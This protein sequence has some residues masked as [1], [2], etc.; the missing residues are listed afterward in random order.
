MTMKKTVILLLVSFLLLPATLLAKKKKAEIAVPKSVL[1]MDEQQY[2]D[3]LYF[4]AITQEQCHRLDSAINLMQT[5]VNFYDSALMS[6]GYEVGMSLDAPIDEEDD[7]PLGKPVTSIEAPGLAA[8]LFFLSN[9]YRQQNNAV[10]SIVNIA[11]ATAIDSVNYWYNDAHADLMMVLKRT[12]DAQVVYERLARNYPDKSQPLYALSDIYLRQDSTDKCLDVLNRLE[13]IEGGSPQLTEYKFFILQKAGRAEEGFEEYRKLIT[14]HPYN[15]QYRIKLGD[16]QMQNAQIQDAKKTYDEAA[17][18]E[19]DNAYVWIALSNYYS[20]TGN[21][22]EADS[23]VTE[24]LV[25]PNL[26]VETKNTVMTEYLKGTY[27]KFATYR[28]RLKAG[29]ADVEPLDT[30]ALLHK[31]DELFSTV[32]AQ[33]PS[34]PEFYE[35]QSEWFSTQ[36]KDSIAAECIRFAVDL[37]PTNP[38][39]WERYLY[40]STSWL[41]K[42]QMIARCDEALKQHPDMQAAYLVKAWVYVQLDQRDKAIDQYLLA[43][44]HVTPPDANQI[45]SLWGNIGDLY[46]LDN[47]DE[48]AY[49]CYEKSLKYNPNNFAVLNNYAYYLS[50]AQKELSRAESMALKVVQKYPTNSTYLDTYAWILY[51]E[52]SYVLADFYQQKALEN[53]E[54]DATDVSTLYDHYGDIKV[55][56]NDIKG[57]VELWK[58]ALECTDCKEPE[59]I[60]KK[61]SSAETLGF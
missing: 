60:R 21:Q 16:L 30:T 22:A 18:I 40:Y 52:G 56:N 32:T 20:M 44:D 28:E 49:E 29:Q 59:P 5:A 34:A 2:F 48:K 39:Y 17:V 6:R 14:N 10:G 31:V 7:R 27:R 25:N 13:E 57:A 53:L 8:A 37:K 9:Q 43:I 35:L 23:L 38:E 50:Q 46:H 42:D 19:P 4:L 47:L 11:R 45:S 26:D 24:A 3:S 33:H 1:T 15:V 61:I 55:K 41:P 12:E 51:L 54:P 58:K 36:R